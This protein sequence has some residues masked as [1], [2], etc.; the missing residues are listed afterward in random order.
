MMI[1]IASWQIPLSSVHLLGIL[2]SLLTFGDLRFPIPDHI[3]RGDR[4]LF[5]I[6]RQSVR[7]SRTVRTRA[8]CCI[9]RGRGVSACD[10]Q[11][12]GFRAEL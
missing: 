12:F 2:S 9:P 11:C 3:N 8:S 7:G 10:M 4:L 1:T 6:F 5:L